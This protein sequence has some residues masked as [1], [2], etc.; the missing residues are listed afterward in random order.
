M[1]V[2]LLELVEAEQRAQEEGEELLP[3]GKIKALMAKG[4]VAVI[5]DNQMEA[6]KIG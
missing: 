4:R 5:T 3:E 6:L 2:Q 1:E